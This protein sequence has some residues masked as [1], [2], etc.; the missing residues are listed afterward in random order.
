MQA[1]I[2]S[3]KKKYH[4]F[5]GFT[6]FCWFDYIIVFLMSTLCWF[7][8][9]AIYYEYNGDKQRALE[10]YI[11]CA[12]WRRAHSIFMTSIAH[13]LF[14]NGKCFWSTR[15]QPVRYTA[16]V[17][18]HKQKIKECLCFFLKFGHLLLFFRKTLR[19]MENYKF[20]GGIQG[21]N[22]RLGFRCWYL[23][24]FLWFE[25]FNE[26]RGYH[27]WHGM[28]PCKVNFIYFFLFLTV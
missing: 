2:R 24:G 1:N 10:N 11:G 13:A 28:N 9:Q 21:W 4:L 17:A 15:F 26:R 20:N 12:N 19:N 23:F 16:M 25:E 3:W 6:F 8:M 5:K 14:L 22:F 27:E 18:V 7:F